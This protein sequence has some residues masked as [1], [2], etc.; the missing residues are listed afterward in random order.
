M[1][2]KRKDM[3]QSNT[4]SKD[5]VIT[6]NSPPGVKFYSLIDVVQTERI[7]S[8]VE[9]GNLVFLNIGRISAFPERKNEFLKNLKK[10]SA[11]LHAT[12]KMVSEETVMVAP[13]TVPIEI[14]SLSPEKISK[15]RT[16]KLKME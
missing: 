8:E 12:L 9:S 2:K 7:L 6:V 3:R 13:S 5:E 10:S 15:D 11:M 16:D 1:A 4:G 14:R